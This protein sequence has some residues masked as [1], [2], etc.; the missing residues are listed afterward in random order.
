MTHAYCSGAVEVGEPP[1]RTT[2]LPYEMT[3]PPLGFAIEVADA[4]KLSPFRT[5]TAPAL[6]SERALIE[7]LSSRECSM[8]TPKLRER[9]LVP[10]PGSVRQTQNHLP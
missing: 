3:C 4:I 9:H 10:P 2:L 6:P 1:L 7:F 8:R 5:T